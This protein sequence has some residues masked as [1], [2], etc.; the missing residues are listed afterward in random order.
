MTSILDNEKVREYFGEC[1]CGQDCDTPCRYAADA[2]L[3]AMQQPIKRGERYLVIRM[4]GGYEIDVIEEVEASFT[5][6]PLT[7]WH[8]SYLRLPD[9]WQKK[10]CCTWVGRC[11]TCGRDKYAE[12]QPAPE[13]EKESSAVEEKIKELV[14]GHKPSCDATEDFEDQLRA[15][16]ALARGT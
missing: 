4:K 12:D 2:V 10:E 13:P 15:L 14:I 7:G 6:D 16:V 9:R 5:R 8:S 1:V 11:D 3:R